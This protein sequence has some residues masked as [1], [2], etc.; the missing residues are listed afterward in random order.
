MA[1][2]LEHPAQAGREQVA[3]VVVPGM[4]MA[5]GIPTK[6]RRTGGV[7]FPPQYRA[8]DDVGLPLSNNVKY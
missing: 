3:V 1:E 5:S 8:W 6:L 2:V 7:E 4:M